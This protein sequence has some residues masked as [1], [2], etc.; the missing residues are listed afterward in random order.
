MSFRRSSLLTVLI[1]L[2]IAG[3]LA[4]VLITPDPTDDVHAVVR[5]HTTPHI[6][7]VVFLLLP[8]PLLLMAGK[9]HGSQMA[10]AASTKSLQLLCTCRC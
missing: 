5:P 6:P 2:L 9:L 7:A 3:A 4:T 10:D 8:L 1:A